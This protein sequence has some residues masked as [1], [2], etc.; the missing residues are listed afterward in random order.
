MLLVFATT[1][2]L[3]KSAVPAAITFIKLR[4]SDELFQMAIIGYCMTC[5][6]IC[7]KL[8]LS[9][10][11]GAFLAGIMLSSFEH[12]HSVLHSTEQVRNVFTGLFLASIGLVISP[13]F[14]L[15]HLRVLSVG[16]AVVLILKAAL[17]SVVVWQFKVSWNTAVVVGVS[18]AQ[19][20]RLPFWYPRRKHA[21][22]QHSRMDAR[23]R[24]RSLP[25]AATRSG[26]RVG[27]TDPWQACDALTARTRFVRARVRG[28]GACVT[29]SMGTMEP[30]HSAVSR[31]HRTT[32]DAGW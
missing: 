10:E 30:A 1:A 3:T 12:N 22:C 20:R 28:A 27:Q 17:I 4:F 32:P 26:T 6:W 14:I 23:A 5:A 25:H 29:D 31:Q 7:G 11:L 24:P 13:V 15:E 8:G 16:A 9:H 21:P 19:V 18:L 2:L